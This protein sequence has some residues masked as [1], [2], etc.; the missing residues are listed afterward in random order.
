[1]DSRE[2]HFEELLNVNCERQT[3]NDDEE[4]IREQKEERRDKAMK[5]EKETKYLR[6]IEAIKRRDRARN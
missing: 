4:D 1:M 3:R 2:E 6:R 5:I